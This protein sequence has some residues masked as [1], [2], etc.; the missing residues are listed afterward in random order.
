MTSRA[1][2]LVIVAPSLQ[3]LTRGQEVQGD[4]L[5]RSWSGDPEL[6][7]TLLECNKR[8][9]GMFAWCEKIPGV[10]TLL[11]LPFRAISTWQAVR[12]ADLVHAFSGSHTSFLLATVPAIGAA[13]LAG[14]PVVVHYHSPRG[15]AHLAGSR[16]ARAVLRRCHAVVVP[17]R[18]LQMVFARHGLD[19]DVIPNVVDSAR[20]PFRE[21]QICG[22]KLLCTRGFEKRYAVD[23]VVRAFALIVQQIPSATLTLAG[24]GPEEQSLR[25]LAQSLALS[26]AITFYGEATRDEIAGLLRDA[27]VLVNASR[28][29]NM[30]VSILEAFASGVPVVSTD[31]GGIPFVACHNV[32]ALLVA[33]GDA[34]TLAV[35]TLAVLRDQR[36]AARL[37][38][39]GRN[40]VDS[41]R[42]EAVRPSWLSVYQRITLR[43]S[44]AVL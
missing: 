23:D 20:F 3:Q 36:L 24:G 37:R 40:V 35:H 26:D 17:S 15:E 4:Q 11:R 14:V 32:S 22:A 7:A 33:P 9:P 30:P 34:E 28:I 16:F 43:S 10:R 38:Y 6:E 42:W 13:M 5:L 31:A 25:K 2:R 19:A 29:D 8:L 12:H 41:C 21:Q 1:L 39:A 27:S 44:S 18:Y